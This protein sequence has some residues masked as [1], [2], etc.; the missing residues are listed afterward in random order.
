MDP[1][2]AVDGVVDLCHSISV[3]DANISHVGDTQPMPRAVVKVAPSP[4]SRRKQSMT[5]RN[6]NVK[7]LARHVRSVHNNVRHHCSV[8]GNGFTRPCNRIQ[9][10]VIVCKVVHPPD[11]MKRFVVKGF[12][13]EM[14]G[15]G[16]SYSIQDDFDRHMEKH[17]GEER[18]HR[19]LG[20]QDLNYQHVA[21]K[22]DTPID[23][24]DSGP[25]SVDIVEGILVGA[26]NANAT[27][28][29]AGKAVIARSSRPDPLTIEKPLETTSRALTYGLKRSKK[30][31]CEDCHKMFLSRNDLGH[32]VRSVHECVRY[33][34]SVCG[35][36]LTKPRHR[37][38]HE[39]TMC[40]VIHPPELLIQ[41]GIKLH[42]CDVLG[43]GKVF[44]KPGDFARHRQKHPVVNQAASEE[45]S[46]VIKK[47]REESD[48]DW[49]AEAHAGITLPKPL[50]VDKVDET[51]I[52]EIVC[53][54]FVG[55]PA[56]LHGN[57]VNALTARATQIIS[58]VPCDVC[59]KT[60]SSHN[61][62]SV[63]GIFCTLINSPAGTS[64]LGRRAY[65]CVDDE[66]GCSYSQV[67]DLR[68]HLA[69]KH[70]IFNVQ[71]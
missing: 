61:L 27:K 7:R 20:G 6:S 69:I 23:I 5:S 50:H 55:G 53:R 70:G 24:E 60:F 36:G 57:C 51:S 47:E 1:L 15:C 14:V 71:E 64:G 31:K 11:I 9:H 19:D 52:A 37:I 10:E 49:A 32:H 45:Q 33:P 35:K 28:C 2:G 46:F 63:E 65:P 67:A 22:Q 29:D 13:C 59:G 54:I 21:I 8:C 48:D 39:A 12:K 62:D 16:K 66:C 56:K 68:R 42:K 41:L 40:R 26:S 34:C 25:S 30:V 3:Y 18:L 44:Q 58:M 4:T 38:E 43:C 17:A